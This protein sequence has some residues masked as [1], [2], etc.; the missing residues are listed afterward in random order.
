V[1]L[2]VGSV[3]WKLQCGI[4]VA[5]A[6]NCG[7]TL[8]KVVNWAETSGFA[9]FDAADAEPAANVARTASTMPTIS[10]LDVR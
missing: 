6:R 3:Y 4:V 2:F 1:T 10:H 8:P 5:F 9:A 7:S